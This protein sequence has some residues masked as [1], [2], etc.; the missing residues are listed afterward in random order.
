M[1]IIFLSLL[2][3]SCKKDEDCE[4]CIKVCTDCDDIEKPYDEDV[5]P[6]YNAVP[7]QSSP[8]VLILMYHNLVYGRTGSVYNCDIVN[9]ENE[10]M[11]IRK[12]F[13]VIDFYDLQKINSGELK[14]NTD[15]AIITFDDGDLSMYPLAFPMLKKYNFKATFFIVSSFVGTVGY[16]NWEQIA[17]IDAYKNKKGVDLFTIG[18]H[19]ATHAALGDI[20]LTQVE[21]ELKE[22]KQ[23][24]STK[25][26]SQ[27][28]FFSLP[29]GSGLNNQDILALIKSA[30]YK[31]MRTSTVAAISTYPFDMYNLPAVNIENYSY[32]TFINQVKSI[33]GR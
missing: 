13:K 9:F 20:S 27:V 11:Y 17:E 16:L 25:L 29:Y 30:G 1:T 32:E 2:T 21:T 15:A 3:L 33:T 19:T 23:V 22:S 28:D 14:L 4:E 5:M 18:S 7:E 8:K 26:N 24:I 12:N 6:E 31:G 10:M